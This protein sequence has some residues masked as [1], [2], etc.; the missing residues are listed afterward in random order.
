MWCVCLERS[1]GEQTLAYLMTICRIFH[2]ISSVMTRR[3]KGKGKGRTGGSAAA[4]KGWRTDPSGG[5]G[6]S[7]CGRE[8]EYTHS[9]LL[10]PL[11]LPLPPLSPSLCAAT[12][13]RRQ[14]IG[15]LRVTQQRVQQEQQEQEEEENA[16]ITG[17][18]PRK[19]GKKIVF[20]GF[21]VRA[22]PL[23]SLLPFFEQQA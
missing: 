16:H 17:I 14:A 11:S 19:S 3:R 22:A 1:S 10:S 7:V 20:D 21:E 4:S 13:R 23:P 9:L 18:R 6:E 5:D 15:R 12:R 8:G 2:H